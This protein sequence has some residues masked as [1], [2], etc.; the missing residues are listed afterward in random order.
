MSHTPPPIR[1]VREIPKL[2]GLTEPEFFAVVLKHM[3]TCHKHEDFRTQT[4]AQWAVS[5][6]HR[7]TE[8]LQCNGCLRLE[9]FN[10]AHNDTGSLDEYVCSLLR[11]AVKFNV[12]HEK[13]LVPQ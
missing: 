1:W 4:P 7:D 11:Q 12:K 6:L 13:C 2:D 8:E 9:R 10:V 5:I 3:E